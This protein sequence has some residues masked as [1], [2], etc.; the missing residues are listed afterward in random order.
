V[1]YKFPLRR[2]RRTREGTVQMDLQEMECWAWTGFI[3]LGIGI[4]GGLL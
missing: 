1:G 2:P 3:W 4:G